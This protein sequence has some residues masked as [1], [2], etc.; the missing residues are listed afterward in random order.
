M[1]PALPRRIVQL[2]WAVVLAAGTAS[3]TAQG[4][5]GWTVMGHQGLVQLVLVPL[6]EASDRAAYTREITRLCEPERTCFLNFY[7]NSQGLPATLP[8]ADGIAQEATATYRRSM[9]NGADRFWWSC[10]LQI[11]G[12]SCF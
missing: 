10:R 4:A 2:A 3:T 5:A 9:K 7:T 12:E 8:L 1:T 11:A 6:A